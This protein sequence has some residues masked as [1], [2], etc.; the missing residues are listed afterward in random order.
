MSNDPFPDAQRLGAPADNDVSAYQ[1]T[2]GELAQHSGMAVCER[3]KLVVEGL[4]E[5]VGRSGKSPRRLAR[6]ALRELGAQAGLFA[7]RRL[8]R[9]AERI[10][11]R[12]EALRHS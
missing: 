7:S 5:R 2:F 4:H 9:L 6:R 3:F 1:E 11:R 8:V 12:A 10:E